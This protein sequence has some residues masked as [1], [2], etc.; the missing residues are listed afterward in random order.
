MLKYLY[1]GTFEKCKLFLNALWAT[2]HRIKLK[3]TIIPLL[4]RL[5]PHWD[6]SPPGPRLPN[7]NTPKYDNSKRWIQDFHG[8][9]GGGRKYHTGPA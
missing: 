6:N 1:W 9:G 2:P 3:P 8:G 4:Y 7:R 5:T